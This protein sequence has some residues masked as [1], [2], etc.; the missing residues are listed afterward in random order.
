MFCNS[1]EEYSLLYLENE[2]STKEKKLFIKHINKCDRCKRM[3]NL[4]RSNY[5]PETKVAVKSPVVSDKINILIDRGRYP[6]TKTVNKVF[7]KKRIVLVSVIVIL[8]VFATVNA[9][10]IYKTYKELVN[11]MF[12][13]R[14][15][16]NMSGI[17]HTGMYSDKDYV[18]SVYVKYQDRIDEYI[19]GMKTAEISKLEY[20]EDGENFKVQIAKGIKGNFISYG[21]EGYT[22]FHNEFFDKYTMGLA[23]GMQ[24]IFNNREEYY[25]IDELLNAAGIC[26]ILGYVPDGYNFKSSYLVSRN[27]GGNI[28]D[29]LGLRY[30]KAEDESLYIALT[31]R[32]K[33]IDNVDVANEEKHAATNE[34]LDINGYQA[35]YIEEDVESSKKDE[36]YKTFRSVSVFLGDQAKLPILLVESASLGR[37]ELINVAGNITVNNISKNQIKAEEYFRGIKDENILAYADKYLDNIK[38]G[39]TEFKFK[40]DKNTE[41]YKSGNNDTYY[42]MYRNADINKISSFIQ[43]PIKLNDDF[44]NRFQR[45]DVQVSGQPYNEQKSVY[46][47][48]KNENN[49]TFSLF[50][51]KM[52]RIGEE[53]GL[54]DQLIAKMSGIQYEAEPLFSSSGHLYYL[55]ESTKKTWILQTLYEENDLVGS[56]NFSIDKKIL[57][58]REAIIKFINSL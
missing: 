30:Q 15:L 27:Q 54:T 23:Q 42:I 44:L 24:S 31:R 53:L 29:E 9:K 8:S 50:S 56:Y 16:L 19:T 5:H 43:L 45:S 21:F 46:L 40:I 35:V 52:R 39:K 13:D 36:V 12:V 1:I 34:E 51:D 37:E 10:T 32:R 17:I 41:F 2:V 4:I 26:P 58:D 47:N 25:S 33:A 3:Y 18:K 49:N 57:S 14:S 55:I 6:D 11:S 7:S 28:P 48:L 22:I 20:D 38:A